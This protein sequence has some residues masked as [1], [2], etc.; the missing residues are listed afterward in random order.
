LKKIILTLSGFKSTNNDYI[1][2]NFFQLSMFKQ[3]ED[4]IFKDLLKKNW[5]QFNEEF[6]ETYFMLLNKV[7]CNYSHD[8]LLQYKEHY[9]V[10]SYFFSKDN[11]RDIK[12]KPF[13]YLKFNA[14]K[15]IEYL[16]KKDSKVFYSKTKKKYIFK[17]NEKEKKIEDI[18]YLIPNSN[19]EKINGAINTF[20][21]YLSNFSV[22]EKFEQYKTENLL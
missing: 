22:T 13:L 6:G 12:E 9:K 18:I 15:A 4:S 20:K 14:C 8:K 7:F 17:N 21:T 2:Y 10:L 19:F 16:F 3:N 11:V 1:S 5:V